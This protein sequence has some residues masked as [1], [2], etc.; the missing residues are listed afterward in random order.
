MGKAAL[1]S[2]LFSCPCSREEE[3][4]ASWMEYSIW[5]QW[6]RLAN[7]C[8]TVAGKAIYCS[9]CKMSKVLVICIVLSLC[10]CK[11]TYTI[12]TI[13]FIFL[14]VLLKPN[15]MNCWNIIAFCRILCLGH[16]API[17]HYWVLIGRTNHSNWVICSWNSSWYYSLVSVQIIGY[18]PG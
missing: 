2:L 14:C 3:I 9:F 16:I 10:I 17:H 4:W 12:F 13:K 5:I 7:Q 11:E 6:I 1:W 18:Y 8:E 15:F